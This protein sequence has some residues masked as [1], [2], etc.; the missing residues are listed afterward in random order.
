MAEARVKALTVATG[1]PEGPDPILPAAWSAGGKGA[2][3]DAQR[4]PVANTILNL[5]VILF[6]AWV[7]YLALRRDAAP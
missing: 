5:L 6:L 2:A 3:V 1:F 7:A 4:S